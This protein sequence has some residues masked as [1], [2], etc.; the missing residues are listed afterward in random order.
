MDGFLPIHHAVLQSHEKVVEV[1]R[2]HFPIAYVVCILYDIFDFEVDPHIL[3][4]ILVLF[5]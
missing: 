3:L 2:Q 1:F 4:G 5:L